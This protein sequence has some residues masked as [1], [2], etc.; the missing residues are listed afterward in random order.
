M[1]EVDDKNATVRHPSFT[2]APVINYYMYTSRDA[3]RAETCGANCR[4]ASH[5][6]LTRQGG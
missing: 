4:T 3:G 5:K 1:V 6:H 2:I